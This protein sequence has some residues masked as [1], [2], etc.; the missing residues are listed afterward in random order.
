[1]FS[2]SKLC[3]WKTNLLNIQKEQNN[4]FLDISSQ[5]LIIRW[6]NNFTIINKKFKISQSF[7]CQVY[8]NEAVIK[9]V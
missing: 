3:E 8:V 1:M 7:K 6:K 9:A 2:I 5:S 4:I